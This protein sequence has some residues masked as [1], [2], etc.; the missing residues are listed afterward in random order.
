MRNL[1][2]YYTTGWSGSYHNEISEHW[3]AA[4]DGE[5]FNVLKSY[6]TPQKV[7]FPEGVRI[8]QI[9]AGE[10][11]SYA[12]DTN[13]NVWAW[14]DNTVGQMGN[15][16]W[17]DPYEFTRDW[18]HDW[19]WGWGYKNDVG[20]TDNNNYVPQQVMNVGA[21]TGNGDYL[22]NVASVT[23]GRDYALALAG[24]RAP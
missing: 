21:T 2:H 7:L 11:T 4:T 19:W 14:G 3:T 23:A 6:T 17:A 8:V 20:Y 10:Y 1:Y 9:A 16:R 12:V 15:G 22:S 24:Q 18:Y 13:G 5:D